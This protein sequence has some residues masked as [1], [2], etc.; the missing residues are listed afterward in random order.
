[1][2]CW[3]VKNPKGQFYPLYAHELGLDAYFLWRASITAGV[4]L[5]YTDQCSDDIYYYEGVEAC[6][7][8]IPPHDFTA[9]LDVICDDSQL[10]NM[11]AK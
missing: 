6:T 5:D 4:Y 11:G 8:Y 9:L 1:M 2:G 3:R 7:S 10:R